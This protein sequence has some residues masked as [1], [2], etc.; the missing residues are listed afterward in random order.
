MSS[1]E[2]GAATVPDTEV[3][4]TR[5]E[6]YNPSIFEAA[7]DAR[8]G[9]GS[10]LRGLS[11]GFSPEADQTVPEGAIYLGF[12]SLPADVQQ[13]LTEGAAERELLVRFRRALG[14]RME[15]LELLASEEK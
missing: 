3:I 9:T 2:Y 8:M 13:E 11:E 14:K 10:G 4:G 15:E 5:I 12:L 1:G 6:D 7:V